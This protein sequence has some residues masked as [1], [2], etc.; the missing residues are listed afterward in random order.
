MRKQILCLCLSKMGNS[1]EAWCAFLLVMVWWN[2]NYNRYPR[3]LCMFGFTF[4][5]TC[6]CKANTW[7]EHTIILIKQT[8][9]TK[10]LRG[11]HACVYK[12]ICVSFLLHR[13]NV[14]FSTNIVSIAYIHYRYNVYCSYVTFVWRNLQNDQQNKRLTVHDRH[15]IGCGVFIFFFNIPCYSA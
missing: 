1:S 5:R 12:S 13:L 7:C 6:V 10:E 14:K 15:W 3:L 9:M 8:K 11:V 2:A 4:I